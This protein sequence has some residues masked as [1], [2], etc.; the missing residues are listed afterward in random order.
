MI[1]K[2]SRPDK[3]FQ[4]CQ[5]AWSESCWCLQVINQCT[6]KAKAVYSTCSALVMPAPCPA[7]VHM[8]VSMHP[9]I[10]HIS[11]SSCH[12][13]VKEKGF[14]NIEWQEL[15]IVFHW[16]NYYA[17]ITLWLTKS[18]CLCVQSASN[19]EGHYTASA[20]WMDMLGYVRQKRGNPEHTNK[21]SDFKAQ[22]RNASALLLGRLQA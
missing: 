4:N 20:Q 10:S 16:Y 1:Y 3:R 15:N 14:L 9:H 17:Q 22:R 19:M 12:D 6:N 2:Q 11:I 13:Y 18:H 5:Y 7:I 8:H 21:E